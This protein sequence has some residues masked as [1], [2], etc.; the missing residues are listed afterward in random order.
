LGPGADKLTAEEK[1]LLQQLNEKY[2]TLG[3]SPLSVAITGEKDQT[4]D[5]KLSLNK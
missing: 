5:I 1:K 4:F 2:G 3:K